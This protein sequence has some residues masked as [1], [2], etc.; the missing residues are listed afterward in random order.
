MK[1]IDFLTNYLDFY[2]QQIPE[3]GSTVAA[4]KERHLKK[5]QGKRIVTNALNFLISQNYSR[6]EEEYTYI[7]DVY[8]T[9]FKVP[10]TIMDVRAIQDTDGKW[11]IPEGNKLFGIRA[12]G[13]IIYNPD[14]WDKGDTITMKVKRFHDTIVNDDDEI[15]FPFEYLQLLILEVKRIVCDVLG[16]EFTSNED[17]KYN[18]MLVNW[19]VDSGKIKQKNRLSFSSKAYGRR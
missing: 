1:Y 7:F 2:L 5:E 13:E 9:N 11:F 12:K 3:S 4:D 17:G 15:N 14:G 8:T 10:D 16:K 19:R 18:Q 6:Y